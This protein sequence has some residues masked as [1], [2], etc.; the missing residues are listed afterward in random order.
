M[1]TNA[2]MVAKQT[3]LRR[4]SPNYAILRAGQ[5]GRKSELLATMSSRGLTY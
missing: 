2:A 5:R 1:S 3:A 4:Y